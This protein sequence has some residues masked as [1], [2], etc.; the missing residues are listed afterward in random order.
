MSKYGYIFNFVTWLA[1]SRKAS[2]SMAKVYT[3]HCVC[4]WGQQHGVDTHGSTTTGERCVSGERSLREPS[5]ALH[6]PPPHQNPHSQHFLFSF[7][8]SFLSS[9]FKHVWNH[10]PVSGLIQSCVVLVDAMCKVN[11][12]ECIWQAVA[13]RL[14]LHHTTEINQLSTHMHGYPPQLII[15]LPSW[16]FP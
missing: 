11:K 9:T 10:G 16:K 5:V 15:S 2:G 6:S 8:H 13:G 14:R 7:L 12:Y 1:I 3:A 4:M